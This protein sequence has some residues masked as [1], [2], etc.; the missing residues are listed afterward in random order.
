[1]QLDF[2]ITSLSHP[3]KS[4]RLAAVYNC[5]NC[6]ENVCLGFVGGE[7]SSCKPHVLILTLLAPVLWNTGRICPEDHHI[8]P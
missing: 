6:W 8:I 4:S 1:M 5:G 2:G 7:L 3:D